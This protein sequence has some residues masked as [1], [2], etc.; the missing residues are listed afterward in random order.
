MLDENVID[1][2]LGKSR[3]DDSGHDQCEAN[4]D[5]QGDGQLRGTQFAQ[6]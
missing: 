2:D 5:E 3:S 6:Q 4:G 1:K